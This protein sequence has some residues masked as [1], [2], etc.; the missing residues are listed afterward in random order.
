MPFHITAKHSYETCPGIQ[1]GT[2]SDE[3]RDLT[4]WLEGNQD[5]KIIGHGDTTL[6]HFV[7]SI[8]S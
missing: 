3:V 2:Q 1:H 4:A 8:R 6:P 5:V 7:C